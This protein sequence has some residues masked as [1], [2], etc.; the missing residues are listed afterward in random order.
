MAHLAR[1]DLQPHA[2]R[3]LRHRKLQ[4]LA[5]LQRHL[6]QHFDGQVRNRDAD[7]I[8]VELLQHCGVNHRP[9]LQGNRRRGL[10]GND[11]NTGLMAI[12][13]RK[14]SARTLAPAS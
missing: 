8:G 14:S 10:G 5:G 12:D 4:L 11:R 2:L 7:Q 3:R 6:G 9:R 13:M 1:H